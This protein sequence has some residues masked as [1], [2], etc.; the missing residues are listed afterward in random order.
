MAAVFGAKISAC[1]S[2]RLARNSILLRL[3]FGMRGF[4]RL[5]PLYKKTVHRLFNRLFRQAT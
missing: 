2:G 3:L 4:C 1:G 5:K